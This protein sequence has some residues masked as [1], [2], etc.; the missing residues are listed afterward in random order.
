MGIMLNLVFVFP[1]CLQMFVGCQALNVNLPWNTAKVVD[2]SGMVRELHIS[3]RCIYSAGF[4][5]WLVIPSH[6]I[7]P[8]L[9]TTR[10]LLQFALAANFNGNLGNF[11]TSQVTNMNRM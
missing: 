6:T 10:P 4:S 2:M 5:A 3:Y 1:F 7:N 11:D 9:F 8:T